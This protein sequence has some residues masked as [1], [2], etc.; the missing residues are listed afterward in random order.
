[1]DKEKEELLSIR[2]RI[3]KSDIKQQSLEDSIE[4]ISDELEKSKKNRNLLI[5]VFITA[6]FLIAGGMYYLLRKNVLYPGEA[7]AVNTSRV[8]QIQ[9]INDSLKVE[10]L[11]LKTDITKYKTALMPDQDS[12][13]LANEKLRD[14]LLNI[15]RGED[16]ESNVSLE[17]RHCYVKRV[18]RKNDV[19][20]I[21]ADYVEYYEGRKAV[22]KAKENGKAEYDINNKGDTLY[23]LYDNHYVRNRS[24]KIK[25]LELD[26]N[27]R[28]KIS[29]INKISY[30]FPLKALQKV[31]KDKPIL[32]LEI[33]NGIVYRI[34]EQKL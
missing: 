30:N 11:K 28:I 33:K 8:D 23:F 16:E 5:I 31:I 2:Y 21:E 15:Q 27:A 25:I 29:S 7:S 1:M 32:I 10:L 17:R 22:E 24:S 19:V 12:V 6:L 26:D 18:Y 34:T 3:E 4:A 13:T 14:T 9:K 20:F